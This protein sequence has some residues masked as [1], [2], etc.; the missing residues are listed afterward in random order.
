MRYSQL[1]GKTTKN[2]PADEDSVN[3][4][5][6][7]RGGFISKQM[8]GV[9][10]YLPLGLR[11]LNKIQNIIRRELLAVGANEIL[12]PVLTQAESY[13]TTGR[14]KMEILFRTEGAGG[15]KI[16]LNP[17]HEEVVTPL[18]QK[19][20]FS[21]HDLPLSV[22]QIQNKFRDEPRAKSGLLRGREFSMKDMYSFHP[23]KADLDD[24]YQQTINVYHNIYRALGLGERTILTYA[25]GGVF[26]RYSHE[27]QTLCA[28]GEDTIYVCERCNIG[29]NKEIKDEQYCC[30]VC[31][32]EDLTEKKGIEV[33]NIFKLGTRFSEAFKF[34]F[35]DK[36]GKEKLVEMGCYGIGPSRIMGALVEIF[37][38]KHGII[39]PASVA[40]YQAYLTYLGKDAAI[41]AQAEK[42][43]EQLNKRGVE[44]LFDDRAEMSAGAKFADADLIGLPYRLVI[45]E[46]TLAAKGVEIK[47]RDSDEISV[48]ALS[49]AV[50]LLS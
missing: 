28:I 49:D 22:F 35:T 46:K 33:G 34:T 42:F 32:S 23:S 26:S 30:P 40:P 16:M 36:Q 38:D 27:F 21:Y 45:S 1:F 9:Y 41:K 44:V 14:D 25:A 17:T 47:K 4:R 43:Y 13:E 24:Y 11:V 18:A 6:L 12:M 39:W 8:A 50:K 5:Y 31:N 37:H 48:M 7:M 2:F 29:V 15:A 19:Y 20:V 3:A 10:N